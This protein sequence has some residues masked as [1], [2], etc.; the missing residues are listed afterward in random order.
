MSP[1]ILHMLLTEKR[2]ER[3]QPRTPTLPRTR[4]LG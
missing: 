3:R 2:D 1:T 4:V